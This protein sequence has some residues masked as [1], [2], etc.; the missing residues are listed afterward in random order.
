MMDDLEIRNINLHI[1]SKYSDGVLSPKSIIEKAI[2]NNINLISITDHDTVEAFRHLPAS[3]LPLK[4]IPGIE[5]SSTWKGDDVHILGYGVDIDNSEL[6]E[7]LIWMKEG[8]HTR[9]E[10]MLFK[11]SKLG[12]KIP[13]EKVL[14]FAGEMKLIVRPHIAKALVADNHCK[15]KQEAFDLYIGN[16]AP[17]YEPKPVLSTADVINF[18]HNAGGIAIVAHPGKL[19]SI[20]YLADFISFGIDGLEIWHPDHNEGMRK[21]LEE[22]CLKNSLL[23]T[24]G[25][26]FHGDDDAENYIRPVPASEL[27]LSDVQ[28][29][30]ERY[31]CQKM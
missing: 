12:I 16:D 3:H 6:L 8:R 22:F 18:I 11:L 14:S 26:D 21:E 28:T 5:F 13:V 29:I 9:A 7:I 1:H 24:G 19:K 17:A 4:I 15:S 25:S 2:S 20:F 10:K 27:I 30:W 23:Q 31:K